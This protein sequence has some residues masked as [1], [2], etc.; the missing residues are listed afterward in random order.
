MYAPT[1]ATRFLQWGL[2]PVGLAAVLTVASGVPS[3]FSPFSVVV[4][5]PLLLVAGFLPQVLFW[6]A[7]ALF[8]CALLR[9]MDISSGKL[10]TN[11]ST[12]I[13]ES[14]RDT[15]TPFSCVVH[16][17]IRLRCSIPRPG[18][19][20]LVVRLR[21]A[22]DSRACRCFS[23]EPYSSDRQD[24]LRI[25]HRSICVDRMGFVPLVWRTSIG[26]VGTPHNNL[27]HQTD[28]LTSRDGRGAA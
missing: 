14:V 4:V 9:G 2:L 12:S 22:S 6:I 27:V 24:V 15:W 19:D 28:R 18:T 13:D 7:P 8:L 1:Q 3:W 26:Q 23:G 11:Y 16:L 25:P 5:L 21:R 20:D 10:R 17:W